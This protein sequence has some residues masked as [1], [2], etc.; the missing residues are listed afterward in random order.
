[1]CYVKNQQH[2]NWRIQHFITHPLIIPTHFRWRIYSII[3]KLQPTLEGGHLEQ[4][5]VRHRNIVKVDGGVQPDG[6]VLHKAGL[7]VRD[8]L[9]VDCDQGLLVNALYDIKDNGL[10]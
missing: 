6:V 9:G 10:A 2:L 4:G 7:N 3:H 8:Y 1:M 5:Q